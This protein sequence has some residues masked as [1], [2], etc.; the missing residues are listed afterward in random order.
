M[1]TTLSDDSLPKAGEG[2]DAV[3]EFGKTKEGNKI[4]DQR[5]WQGL[6]AE[7]A[8]LLDICMLH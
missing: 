1:S 5:R 2:F 7:F 8:T 3:G 6:I 4:F